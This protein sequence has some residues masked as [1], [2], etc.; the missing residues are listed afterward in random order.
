MAERDTVR[1]GG[2]AAESHQKAWVNLSALRLSDDPSE[3]FKESFVGA[4]GPCFLFLF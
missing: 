1:L 4:Y 2:M 3:A